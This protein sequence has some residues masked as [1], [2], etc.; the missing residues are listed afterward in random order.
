MFKRVDPYFLLLLFFSIFAIGP[1]LGPGYFWSAHDG[2]HSVY[3]L[4]EFD[5]AIQDGIWYPRWAPDFTFGFGYPFFN[6]Y[7][8]G[9]FFVGEALHLM[10][11]DF[12]TA[13]KI[14][15]AL[16]MVYAGPAMFAFVKRLTTSPVSSATM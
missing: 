11:F 15:F 9:A 10:G 3:F 8:P 1:L 5:R 2:R 13:T 6:I 7:A 4:F 16:A 12:V 14:V